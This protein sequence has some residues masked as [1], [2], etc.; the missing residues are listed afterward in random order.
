MISKFRCGRCGKLMA[1]VAVL[2]FTTVVIATQAQA[3]IFDTG[4]YDFSARWDNTVTY[5]AVARIADKEEKFL[6]D[7]NHDD[8]TRNF[9][10]GLV[11]NRFDLLSELDLQYKKFGVRFTGAGWYDFVYNTTNDNDSPGTFNPT[12]VPNNE[13]TD[14][15]KRLHGRDAELL[16]AFTFGRFDLG[17]MTLRYRAGQFTQWW[18]DSFFLGWNGVAGG[19][20]PV[21]VAKAATLPNVQL[22]ELIRPIPQVSASL[23]VTDALSFD[24]YYQFKWEPARL[25][26]TGSYFSPVD[27]IGP[28][29]ERILAG[30]FAFVRRGDVEP[31]DS[32]QFGLNVKLNTF[33]VTYGLY[34]TKFH[35]KDFQVIT[36]LELGTPPGAPDFVVEPLPS[37]YYMAYPEDIESLG[38]SANF[39]VGPYTFAAEVT[40]RDNVPMHS[41]A[42]A[43]TEIL[44]FDKYATWATGKTLSVLL[45]TFSGGMRGNFFCDSQDLIAEVAYVKELSVDDESLLDPAYDKDGIG[46]KVVYTPKWYQVVPGFTFTMPTGIEYAPKGKPSTLL[47]GMGSHKGGS[48]NIGFGGLYEEV[49][50][51]ELTYRNF[52]GDTDYQAHADRDYVSFY[53]RRAF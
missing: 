25:F 24:G 18:G 32:G 21:D 23:Q 42:D 26:A 49:W 34:Y 7:P 14:T 4:N 53:I 52:Y 17:D 9:D 50:E 43:T 35:S 13:F 19:L 1:G 5:S 45:N 22:K 47:W 15:T 39:A 30:P 31:D 48:F 46:V 27:L 33:F 8:A 40:Y 10:K 37:Y 44:A 29:A 51:F 38:A 12:S 3:V 28:G 41:T 6:N 36:G 2:L 11:M 16:E 20:A